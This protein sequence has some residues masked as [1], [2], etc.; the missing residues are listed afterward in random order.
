MRET[1]CYRILKAKRIQKKLSKTEING[2]G[3]AREI[4]EY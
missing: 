4:L 1:V 3:E 2:V